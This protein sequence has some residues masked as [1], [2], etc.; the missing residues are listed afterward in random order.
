MFLMPVCKPKGSEA[1]SIFIAT[2][3]IFGGIHCLA[4]SFPFP[5]RAEM[6]LWWV[7]AICITVAP[8]FLMLG[9]LIGGYIPAIGGVMILL[10]GLVYAATR[11][12]LLVLTFSSLRS[13]P[14]DLYQ[15]PSWS[16]FLPHF[17]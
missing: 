11:V 4:W 7:S 9:E 2:G 15:T 6:I 12:I 17:G 5:T 3:I 1:M 14:P 16:S 13:P 8:V 10:T